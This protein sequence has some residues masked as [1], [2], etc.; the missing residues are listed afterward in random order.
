MFDLVDDRHAIGFCCVIYVKT[1]FTGDALEWSPIFGNDAVSFV[2]LDTIQIVIVFGV[3]ESK[4]R[5]ASST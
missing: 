3:L 2:L 4:T 1:V 5:E